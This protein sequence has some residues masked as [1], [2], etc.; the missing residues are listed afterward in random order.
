MN[1]AN[2]RTYDVLVAGGGVAGVAAAVEAARGGKRVALVEKSTQLGGLATIGLINLFVPLCNGRGTQIIRGMAEE[3][4]QPLDPIR[5]RYHPG[6]MANGEPGQGKTTRRLTCRYSAPIFSLVLC[7]LL[8]GLGVDIWFDSIVTDVQ[9]TGGHID[10]V[11]VFNKSGYSCCM[12]KMFVDTTGDADL[13]WH[14]GVPTVT[15]GNYHTYIAFA[16]TLESCQ[17]AVETGDIGKL[18]A[19]RAGGHANLYGGQASR[20]N[21]SLGW[22]QRG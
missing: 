20:G 13:L 11:V 6:R 7:E 16:A 15:R 3:F 8:T 17:K 12:A 9:T 19:Q 18:R 4:L 10:H 5:L 21:A 14:A 1:F 22:D 2:H